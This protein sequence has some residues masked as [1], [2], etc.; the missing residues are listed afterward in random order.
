MANKYKYTTKFLQPIIASADIDQENIKISKASLEDLKSL[1]PSSV[2]LD[3]NID[4]VGVA[5]NAA[6]VNKFNR[7]HDG[8]STDTALAVKDYFVHKPTNIEHKKQRIVGHIVSA[9]FSG[10]GNNELLSPEELTGTSDPFNISLGAVVYRMVDRR[11]AEL[12][13]K[14][15]DPDSP[16]HNQVSASWEIG[17]NDYQIAVGSENLSEAEIVTD[18][19]QIEELSQYLK[20]SDGRGEMDDGTIVRRLVVGNVYPLGI[21]FTANPAADVEGVVV[22]EQ[23]NQLNMSDRRDL[24]ATLSDEA[25]E[26][27]KNILNFKNNISQTEKNTVKS[28]RESNSSIM[29]TNQL[30]QEIKSVLDEK[31]SSE[32]MSKDT[33]AEESV[34]SISSI[35]N[36]AIREKNEEYKQQLVSEKEEKA[37]IEAQHQELTA[38][39]EEMK[40][41]LEAA[42]EK[43][44][45]FEDEKQHE[46]SLARFNARMEA[47]EQ[48]YELSEADLKIVASEVK[49]LTEADEAFASYQEKLAVVFAHKSKEHLQAE[50]DKF[51]SAVA[52]AVEKRV[53]ELK[54]VKASDDTAVEATKE[55]LEEALEDTE[56]VT[57]EI[58]NTNEASSG[59]T[60]TL[61]TKFQSA[62]SK[63]N[64]KVTY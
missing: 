53:S 43:I 63:E 15:V 30:V 47:V 28:E 35:I 5:F 57:P 42:E 16:M 45:Q 18:E 39:V 38:S 14:S 49:E 9:G 20:A 7:N 24:S 64:I 59:E 33:F 61:R 17:F 11:F 56:Q 51:D 13:N 25:Q 8:I 40:Q 50:K 55:N 44:R 32:K 58:S 34:A 3:K 62:F 1:I 26:I 6:V 46:E 10:Y 60:E 22:S 27:L 2:E 21:G 41:K 37:K 23:N 19:K 4:L 36:E 54:E 12:L 29:N 48:D 31:L 52:E